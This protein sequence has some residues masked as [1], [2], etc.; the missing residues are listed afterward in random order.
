[1][2][3]KPID[4][5]TKEDIESLVTA[6]VGERRTLD[7][8]AQ[9]NV[10][11]DAEKREFL[12]DVSSFANAADGDMIFGITDE[13]DASGK[14]TGLPGSA[15][16]IALPNPSEVILQLENLVRDGVDPRIP[17][18][19]WQQVA[20]FPKGPVL[21]M[22]IPKSWVGPHMVIFG[23]L[24]R[25]YSRNSAGKYQLNV[26]EIRSA[27]AASTSVGDRLRRFRAERIA[28][29]AEDGVPVSLGSGPKLLLHLIPLVALDPTI[30]RD[31]THDATELY[32]KLGPTSTVGNN[33]PFGRR[34]NLD[35]LVTRTEFGQCYLQVFRSGTVECGDGE[36]F[37]HTAEIKIIPQGVEE[38]IRISLVQYLS[39]QKQLGLPLPIFVLVT[40]VGVKG[41]TLRTTH[42]PFEHRTA[43]DRDIL[44]L[45]EV[46]I[47]DYDAIVHVAMRPTF[48]ALWQAC[49]YERS[50]NY[51]NKGE[52]FPRY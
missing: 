34:Y 19:Q 24:S 26:G 33:I 12:S 49:G 38:T 10:S 48:D 11:S 21:V 36:L 51:N 44:P 42:S 7:Y 47:E 13:R 29:A 2:I 4:Q 17:G 8:K 5:V 32:A 16:G 41:F 23:G 6:K 15:D 39:V 46:M 25:F 37:K 14:P 43:I 22:R 31:Y 3:P 20:G 28:K 1:M 9:L 18:I 30:L 35:G 50:F 45:P 40:L 27:F 52:W